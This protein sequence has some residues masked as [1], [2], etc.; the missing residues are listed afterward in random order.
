MELLFLGMLGALIATIPLSY[1]PIFH[2]IKNRPQRFGCID[3]LRGILALM[4]FIHHFVITWN[5]HNGLGWAKPDEAIYSNFGI[6]GVSIFF[7]ITGFLFL[8]R[9]L[10]IQPNRKMGLKLLE[11]RFFRIYPLYLFAVLLVVTLSYISCLKPNSSCTDSAEFYNIISWLLFLPG[12]IGLGDVWGFQDSIKIIAGV[13]W[14]LRYEWIFY[15]VLPGIFI[16]ISKFS[17]KALLILS[18]G[19]WFSYA[20]NLKLVFSFTYFLLFW[21][22]GF[23]AALHNYGWLKRLKGWPDTWKSLLAIP[24]FAGT[25]FYTGKSYDLIHISLMTMF[26][27]LV[28]AGGSIFGILNWKVSLV[29]GEISYSIYLL[30][31]TILFVLFSYFE[32]PL[33]HKSFEEYSYSIF[34]IAAMIPVVSILSFYFIEHPFIKIGKKY[35][36]TNYFSKLLA[37]VL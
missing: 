36:L 13:H 12:A 35:Y 15:F 27:I 19:V 25:I 11:S 23:V 4:V 24:I 22:G 16:L 28:V 5:W 8:G 29:L 17:I 21:M 30:H 33:I 3:G 34:W 14:T 26:F 18:I 2:S 7:M 6:V 20:I 1:I 37:R 31:G 32:L 10:P 9:M